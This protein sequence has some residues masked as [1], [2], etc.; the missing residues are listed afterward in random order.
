MSAPLAPLGLYMHWPYCARI[1]P[2]CDF[3]VYRARGRDG[4]ALTHAIIADMKRWRDITGARALT[5]LHFGGGTPSLMPAG[6]I[7]R[8]IDEAEQL[9]GFDANA[10]IGLEA[11][12]NEAARFADIAAAGVE[13]LSLGVQALDDASLKRLGRDHDAAQGLAAFE[14]ARALFKRASFDLIYA[15]EGQTPGGWDAELAQALA[16]A[17]DHMSLYQLTI[18]PGTAFARQA[19]RGDLIAP[20]DEDT[21]RMYEI[22]QTLTGEAGLEAYEISNHARSKAHQSRHNALYWLGA[23]WIG[24]G[25]GAHARIGAHARGGRVGY[26]AAARP[27][28]YVT[29]AVQGAGHKEERLSALAEAQERILMGLRI[30]QGLDR[31][32]LR[33]LTGLDL[34]IEAARAHAQQGRLELTDSR[35]RLTA[36]GR[37]FADRVGFDLAPG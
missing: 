30:D 17:P 2:Y 4:D 10:E 3:N 29:G 15:R 11:N 27:D 8:I 9:W 20:A 12:P 31:E 35:A 13:R 36:E 26:E 23:D 33:A 25:P 34:N 19:E 5:S 1:C 18:E 32:Q 21:A 16:R 37:L 22:A 14:S 7:A 6:D 24:V 28:A